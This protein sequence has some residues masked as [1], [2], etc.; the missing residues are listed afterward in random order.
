MNR[1]LPERVVAAFQQHPVVLPSQGI[2]WEW[3][4]TSDQARCCGTTIL[5]LSEDD[6]PPGF[7]TDHLLPYGAMIEKMAETLDL[8]RNYTS[9]FACGWDGFDVPVHERDIPA[10]VIGYADGKACWQAVQAA[11]HLG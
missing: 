10:F 5:A 1:I 8:D 4:L 2:F 9:G 6:E 11:F 3:L 7:V